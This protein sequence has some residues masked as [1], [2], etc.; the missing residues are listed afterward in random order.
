MTSSGRRPTVEPKSGSSALATG[1]KLIMSAAAK[2]TRSDAT[3]LTRTAMENSTISTSEESNSIGVG[4][5]QPADIGGLRFAVLAWHSSRCCPHTC[6]RH[7]INI[8]KDRGW[9]RREQ[10]IP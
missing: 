2:A 7:A 8:L 4:L 9:Q 6:S 1:R 3:L 10:Q 5:R